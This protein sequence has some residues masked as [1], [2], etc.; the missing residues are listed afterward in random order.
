MMYRKGAKKNLNLYLSALMLQGVALV[1]EIL[2]IGAVMVFA[3]SPTE[4]TIEVLS[5]FSM[6]PVGYANVFPMITGVLTIVIILLGVIALFK[7][8]NTTKLKKAI[9]ICSIF[10][11][12]FSIVP[13]FL[14]GTIGM[15][16]AS[17][18]VFGAILLSICLQAVAIR[19][20]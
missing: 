4:R 3:T 5:Y 9:F 15:T 18:A 8:N 14:F 13:L 16:V 11:L 6:L 17:Y 12:V 19:Q 20:E 10:S 1:L 2:P 7:F